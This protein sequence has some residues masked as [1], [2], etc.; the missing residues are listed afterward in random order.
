M[1]DARTGIDVVNLRAQ[2][3]KHLHID[4]GAKLLLDARTRT[5]VHM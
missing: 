1:L 2:G 3:V 5:D 4:R